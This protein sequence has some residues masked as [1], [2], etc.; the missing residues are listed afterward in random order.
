MLRRDAILR[1][2]VHTTLTAACAS[3]R[4]GKTSLMGQY[5][6]Q[7]FSTQYKA[8]IGADFLSKELSIDEALVTL[9]IWDT[10]GQERFQSL[11]QAFY[12]GADCCV[13]VYDVTDLKSFE[14]LDSWREEF[15]SS[16]DPTNK[17]EFP[18]VVLA[19]KIDRIA[20]RAV[21]ESKLAEWCESKG[22]LQWF[23]CSAKDNVNVE[24]VY[25]PLPHP[26]H[27]SFGLQP[28]SPGTSPGT[29]RLRV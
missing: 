13:L 11:G 10:A 8:T 7:K 24:K 22:G 28:S 21:I 3:L 18:F 16:T 23:E 20:D 29:R 12:R 15:L 25:S 17:N 14:N 2:A 19:N 1:P 4:V 6:H 9:Q 5:V 27:P 26:S